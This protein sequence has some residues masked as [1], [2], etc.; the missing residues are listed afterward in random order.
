MIDSVVQSSLS[1]CAERSKIKLTD[2]SYLQVSSGPYLMDTFPTLI[3][4]EPE[5]KSY[6]I[7]YRL[8]SDVPIPNY[9]EF[10]GMLSIDSP[11]QL[12]SVYHQQTVLCV[13]LWA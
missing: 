12:V 1:L 10:E 2:A 13:L 9:S 7:T 11:T 6:E 8:Q 4:L 5:S 3:V